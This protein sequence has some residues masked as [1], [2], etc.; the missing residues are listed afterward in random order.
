MSEREREVTFSHLRQLSLQ[1]V[2]LD[3]G[4]VQLSVEACAD[5]GHDVINT[6]HVRW[7]RTEEVAVKRKGI[8]LRC[9]A[10]LEREKR[11]KGRKEGR[12][13]GR[14]ERNGQTDGEGK[15]K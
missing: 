15:R 7:W 10:A 14:E 4:R 13:E 3:L 8:N 5:H 9:T 1:Y 12:K 6:L 2:T 11:M